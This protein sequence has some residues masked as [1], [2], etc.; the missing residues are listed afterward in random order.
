MHSDLYLCFHVLYVIYLA[1]AVLFKGKGLLRPDLM[2]FYCESPN[3]S[4][5][6]FE[7]LRNCS[8]TSDTMVNITIGIVQVYEVCLKGTIFVLQI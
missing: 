4:S 8:H 2:L 5:E 6:Y 1:I 3:M 7:Y